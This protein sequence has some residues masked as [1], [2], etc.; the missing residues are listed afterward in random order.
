[1][2][3]K[4]ILLVFLV[5][6]FIIGVSPAAMFAQSVSIVQKIG[7][8]DAE[9]TLNSIGVA[10]IY[11]CT[12]NM[13]EIKT[14]FNSAVDTTLNYF[15]ASADSSSYAITPASNMEEL[16]NSISEWKD[17]LV[18][19]HGYSDDLTKFTNREPL[20]VKMYSVDVLVF[21]WPA[22]I[23][24]GG[25]VSSFRA[26]EDTVAAAMPLF[27]RFLGELSQ[28]VTAHNINCSFLFH[29]LG[30]RFAMLLGQ[31]L[32]LPSGSAVP[33]LSFIDNIVLNEACVPLRDYMDWAGPL[34][35]A[36]SGKLSIVYNRGDVVLKIANTF[37]KHQRLLGQGPTKKTPFIPDK[38]INY[39]DFTP[40]LKFQDPHFSH[41]FY[42]R[43]PK[44]DPA[45]SKEI[46][47]IY[48]KIL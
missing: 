6:I 8:T 2:S 12:R 28:Y 46:I 5:Q 1:M 16:L 10:A 3:R 21:C 17:L 40:V 26:T 48:Q 32:A 20:L 34:S 24:E 35:K 31:E 30:N 15:Y 13:A 39:V 9:N 14:D 7:D 38:K 22:A 4:Y 18:L 41:N 45:K 47:S 29:S 33:D 37:S 44:D 23:K 11:D 36:I 19:V 27:N 42:A 43:H 25:R